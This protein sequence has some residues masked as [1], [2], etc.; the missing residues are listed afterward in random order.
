MPDK[1]TTENEDNTQKRK[2][3]KSNVRLMSQMRECKNFLYFYLAW[4]KLPVLVSQGAESGW[5]SVQQG[6]L[7]TVSWG[8]ESGALA[9]LCVT[10]S[11]CFETHYVDHFQPIWF[12]GSQ[13][14][15]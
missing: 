14:I 10:L 8:V 5:K 4:G 13:Y 12:L 1:N 11:N 2:D 7:R 3:L 9:L 15:A 6:V